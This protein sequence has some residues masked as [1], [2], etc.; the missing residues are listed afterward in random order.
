MFFSPMSID[1][2]LAMLFEG[3]SEKLKD[4]LSEKLGFISNDNDRL[5]QVNQF[6]KFYDLKKGIKHFKR[7]TEYKGGFN[8]K[9]HKEKSEPFT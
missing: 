3:T 7:R 4:I 8:P 1:I 2:A 5:F 9:H 6:M